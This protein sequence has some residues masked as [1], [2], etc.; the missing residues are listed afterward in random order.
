MSKK[1]SRKTIATPINSGQLNLVLNS[2]F[3]DVIIKTLML[4]LNASYN[5]KLGSI[6]Y[7]IA[8]DA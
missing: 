6:I 8:V 4:Q 3:N 5:T 1:T 2:V 7:L